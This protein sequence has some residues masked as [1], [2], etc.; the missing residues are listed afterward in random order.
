MKIVTA[1]QMRQIEQECVRNGISL[2]TLMENAGKAVAEA[3]RR[4]HPSINNQNILVLAGP[5]NNGG[6]GLVA[7]RHLHDRGAEVN[8][9]LCGARPPEDPNIRRLLDR[10][11]TVVEVSQDRDLAQLD[12]LL[13][14]ANDVI[15]A[16]FGTGKL[17][18]LTGVS[19]D[20]L[21]RLNSAKQKKPSLHIIAVDLPSGLNADT[22][23]VDNVTPYADDTITLGFP[24]AGLFLF[25]GAERVG[26]LSI[27]DIGIPANLA[28]GINTGLITRDWA[29]SVLPH[30]PIDANKGTFGRVLVVAGSVNYVGAAYLAC[31]GAVRVGA[32]LVTLATPA[33][34]QPV[35]A[36]RLTEVIYLPLP[37]YQLGIISA[38]AVAAVQGQLEYYDV[39]LVGCGLGQSEPAAVF[40]RG[41]L[42]QPDKLLPP[43][44][45]DADALNILSDVPEWWRKLPPDVIVTPHPGEMSRL[46]RLAVDEVQS[47]RVG[48]TRRLAA[49]WHKT[50]VLKGAYT[51]I[52]AADG[53]VMISPYA[54]P[55]LASAG[56]GDILAGVIA[57]LVAQGVSLFDAAAL[58]VFLHGQAGELVKAKL[59]DMGMTA[60][61]LLPVLPVVIKQLKETCLE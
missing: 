14:S 55:G 29:K 3:I 19:H 50:V 59:G 51:V 22:G 35:L 24:K 15:D 10:K 43:L 9:Y 46:A 13:A 30:R 6:D 49:E 1:D 4:M 34:L 45:L 25:P 32:G 57:G 54:N 56:T 36:S 31:S 21:E 37:D 2:D 61:D 47:D 23:I 40:L 7:A 16:I 28:D 41:V 48:I 60:S 39:A 5:G 38:Q 17:R 44:V 18:P 52:A 12:K 27:A 58:G 11:T 33:S 8:V 53:R 26:R 20:V 42:L